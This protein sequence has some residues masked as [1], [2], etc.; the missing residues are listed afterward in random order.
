MR[1]LGLNSEWA[2]VNKKSDHSQ[3]TIHHSQKTEQWTERIPQ[4]GK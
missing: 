1:S 3:L 2:M 4:G